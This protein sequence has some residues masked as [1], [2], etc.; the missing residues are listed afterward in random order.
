MECTEKNFMLA[1]QLD[2][3]YAFRSFRVKYLGCTNFRGTRVKIID[4]NFGESVTLGFDYKFD[5]I[6]RQAICFLLGQDFEVKGI[7]N[8]GNNETIILCKWTAQPLKKI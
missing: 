3:S 8:A 7:I 6:T 5:T 1:N 2:G 4:C